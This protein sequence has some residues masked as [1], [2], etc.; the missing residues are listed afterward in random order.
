MRIINERDT[1]YIDFEAI[2][3][4]TVFFDEDDEVLMKIRENE[5][6]AK[7]VSLATGRVFDLYDEY[8]CRVVEA[9]LTIK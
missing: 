1:K 9:V 7:A 2:P 3:I 8:E 4:G 5:D 6:E